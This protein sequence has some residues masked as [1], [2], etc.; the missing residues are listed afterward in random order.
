ML[1][2]LEDHP[3]QGHGHSFNTNTNTSITITI[4]TTQLEL[5]ILSE[6]VRII[7]ITTT[8]YFAKTG[9]G[10]NNR[11]VWPPRD[12]RPPFGKDSPKRLEA[13]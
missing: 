1:H 3:L 7:L 13:M 9:Y 4:T 6:I 11:N 2:L 5:R 10:E 12:L 8:P